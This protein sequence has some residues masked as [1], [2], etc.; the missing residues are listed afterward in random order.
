M[1]ND[2]PHR[3]LVAK[4]EGKG[5]S[6]GSDPNLLIQGI[7]REEDV[8]RLHWWPTR[9]CTELHYVEGAWFRC[10]GRYHTNQKGMG[11]VDHTNVRRASL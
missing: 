3:Q 8:L 11:E 2:E 10:G 9:L 1:T 7:T 6:E 5:H 4:Y